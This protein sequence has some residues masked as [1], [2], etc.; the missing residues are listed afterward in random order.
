MKGAT[1]LMRNRNNKFLVRLDDKEYER[2]M[3]RVKKSGLSRESYIRQII[4]NLMPT[5]Q[6]PPDYFAMMK[7][8]HAIGN[9]M[10]QIAQ[11][12]HLINAID[13]QR[14]DEEIAS[15]NKAILKITAAVLLPGKIE[16]IPRQLKHIL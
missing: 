1:L 4:D 2:L 10:N 7:E 12:A 15:L 5:D 9:N 8:L 16:Y 13:S 11:K 14:Y 3:R 6:P